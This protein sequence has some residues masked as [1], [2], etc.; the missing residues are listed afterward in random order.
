MTLEPYEVRVKFEFRIG[1]TGE[2]IQVDM[3][4][5]DI[6]TPPAAEIQFPSILEMPCP[7]LKAYNRETVVAEKIEAMVSLGITNSRM[8]DFYDVYK[9][10]MFDY[11][12]KILKKTVQL[13]FER[14]KTAVPKQL[15]LAFTSDFSD[16]PIKQAQWSAFLRKSSLDSLT[17]KQVVEKIRTFIEPVFS[18]INKLKDYQYK[19]SGNGWSK[20]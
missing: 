4:F 11:D 10:S 2:F 14:R 17:L 18:A 6:V 16:D 13:T 9:L 1:K 19:W 8:K 20:L 15:P 12:G 7:N 5:G 3:G